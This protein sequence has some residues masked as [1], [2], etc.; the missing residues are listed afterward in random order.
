MTIK[1]TS[2]G[3]KGLEGYRVQ[4]EV[5]IK[6]GTESMVIVGLPDASVKESRERVVAA[7]GHFDV[8]VTDQKVV[9]NLSPSEQK[10][11]GPLFDLAIAIAA[12]KELHM[13]KGEIPTDAAFIGAL[14]LDGT[15]VKAEGM[16]PALIA[17]KGLGIKKAYLP[18]DPTIPIH[19]LQGLE[20]VVVQHIEEVVQHLEGQQLLPFHHTLTSNDQ[21]PL[22]TNSHHKD[23]QHV[24]GH[25]Q[26]KRALEIAAAGEHNV[27]MSGP[28]GCG[29][30]LLAETFPSILPTL[31]NQAQLEVMSLYQL[32]GE[33]RSHFQNAPYRNPH[34]SASSVSIIGG[35]S[36][37]RP[38]EISLAHRGVLFLDEIA[39]FTK[40]TIDMLRQPLET[41]QVT[42][43]RAHSTVTYPSS[44][45]LIGAMNPCPC[46]FLGSND[47]YC[48]CSQKQI[49]TYRNRLSGPIFD[50]LDILLS[51]KSINLDQPSKIQ[52]SSLDIRTRVE[53]ARQLQYRRYQSE[54]SNAKIPFEVMTQTSPLTRDQQKMLSSVAAKQNWSN[55][56]QIKIIRLARTISDL[57]GEDKITDTAIWEAMTLR[58]WGLHKQQAVARET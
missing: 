25:E 31:T 11:N 24:I 53:I 1:V 29:K 42:I 18:Y 41:G 8:D 3:L 40:K 26:A 2:V 57:G 50:R 36:S 46:G 49:Q 33:R 47:Y 51:L 15:V 44:F 17:A 14:S 23:F 43:S 48:T 20:C 5:K 32:A 16:L 27:L 22:F 35:G 58:R 10:K 6:T 7:L 30:S 54:I 39:E 38:G 4:V 55:R 28:P 34:H 13:I 45:I 52:E 37:P 9:V 19:M 12:L 56:V 21:I